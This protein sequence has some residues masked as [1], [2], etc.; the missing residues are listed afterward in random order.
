M[1]D[2]TEE[3]VKDPGPLLALAASVAAAARAAAS[4]PAAS[5][6]AATSPTAT[7]PDA[8]G[9]RAQPSPRVQHIRVS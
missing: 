4:S 2:L 9:E 7:N 6:P 3:M 1:L 8:P 5:S